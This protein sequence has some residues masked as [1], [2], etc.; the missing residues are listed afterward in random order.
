M[1]GSVWGIGVPECLLAGNRMGQM[2]AAQ[3]D[4]S[5]RGVK[6]SLVTSVPPA[7]GRCSRG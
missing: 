1:F 3:P 5:G 4:W 2:G 6:Q 7:A